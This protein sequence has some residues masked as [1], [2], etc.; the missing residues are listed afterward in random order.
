[1]NPVFNVLQFLKKVKKILAM[2]FVVNV[3]R[4]RLASRR[5][6]SKPKTSPAGDGGLT[7][8]IPSGTEEGDLF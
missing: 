6:G 1:M 8:G 4:E 5:R 7:S 2:F 3:L